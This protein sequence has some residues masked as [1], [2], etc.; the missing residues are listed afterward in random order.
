MSEAIHFLG[1]L[2][3][4][5]FLREYWQKKPLLVRNAFPDIES[6]LGPDELAGLALDSSDSF[7]EDDADEDE[8]YEIENSQV[9]SR[10]ILSQLDNNN[11]TLWTLEHGPFQEDQLKSLPDKDWTL[12]VQAV[13]IYHDGVAGLLDEFSFIPRWR[14]DD[15][16]ISL[17]APGGNVGPHYDNYDV[18]LIQGMGQRQWKVGDVCSAKSELVNHPDLRILA[19]MNSE[20]DWILNPGDM[21]YLPPL[22]A[23]HGVAIDNCMTFSVGFRAPSV[24]E[25]FDKQTQQIAEKC[26]QELRYND[27]ELKLQS[28]SGW[29][30]EQA[31]E[32][33]QAMM[34]ERIQDKNQLRDWL[35]KLITEPKY[36]MDYEN[37]DAEEETEFPD[38]K[39][40]LALI[41]Q[42]PV[43][44]RDEYSRYVYTGS[45]NKVEKFYING[46][47]IPLPQ[48]DKNQAEAEELII[49][50]C[51]NR[52]YDSERLCA[53]LKHDVLLNWFLRLFYRGYFYIQEY[54]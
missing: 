18:F 20:Q 5:E 51:N 47:D 45:E 22:V 36:P 54:E 48:A 11:Q 46:N 19:D 39:E 41:E 30:S 27:P 42:T 34:M 53:Y 40:F 31:I 32:K 38:S 52:Y 10:I 29:L 12:L 6:L 35:A 4:E 15:V 14:V 23:H 7:I 8:G 2:S 13:D 24:E 49:Y 16:M 28:N 43:L 50:L 25:F 33:V 1:K 9:E 37:T 21:L 44:H 17:A 3:E 26:N